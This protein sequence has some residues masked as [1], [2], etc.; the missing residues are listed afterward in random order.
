MNVTVDDS[1]IACELCT[2]AVPDVFEMGD[3]GLAHAIADP[4]PEDQEDDVREAA[5]GCPTD[6]IHIQE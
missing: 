5:E 3:D 4:V 6:A 1:C 2:S